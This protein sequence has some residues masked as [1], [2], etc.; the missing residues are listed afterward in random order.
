[1]VFALPWRLIKRCPKGLDA[2]RAEL[3][4]RSS[5]EG[6]TT[7]QKDD[8][9]KAIQWDDDYRWSFTP[10]AGSEPKE[11]SRDGDVQCDRI[12]GF[13]LT[14]LVEAEVLAYIDKMEVNET[15]ESRGQPR[16]VAPV[17]ER[18]CRPR[19]TRDR[20]EA[21][22]AL[23]AFSKTQFGNGTSNLRI[24][25]LVDEED[26]EAGMGDGL[27]TID[28]FRL[29]NSWHERFDTKTRNYDMTGI[30]LLDDASGQVVVV[31]GPGN[32]AWEEY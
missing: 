16:V 12:Q 6:E 4:G 26:D 2:A 30:K 24:E 9:D 29:A 13:S 28:S 11:L 23:K 22:R 32:L 8:E 17:P 1:M 7:S 19:R 14:E 21:F 3:A 5:D 15:R 31:R 20:I 25:L 27:T 10:L 18:V